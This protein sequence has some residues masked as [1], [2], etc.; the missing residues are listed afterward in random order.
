MTI[1]KDMVAN[2]Q[3]SI[4]NL[5]GEITKGEITTVVIPQDPALE[6][7]IND[8]IREPIITHAVKITR[9][10]DFKRDTNQE[11]T[12]IK[13]GWGKR[14]CVSMHVSTTGSGKSVLQTQSALCFIH[15]VACC[16]LEP[17]RPMKVWVIQSEDD[18]DRVANDRDDVIRHLSAD[19]PQANWYAAAHEVKFLS[20]KGKT[21]ATF[22]KCLNDELDAAAKENDKPDVVI[23]NPMNAFFGGDLK[24][25]VDCSA[26]FKGG[27]LNGDTTD[28]LEAI[29][30]RHKVW[31]WIFSHTNKPPTGDELRQWLKDD[32][33]EYKMSGANEIADAVRSVITFLK[34]PNREGVFCF[35]AGKNGRGLGWKDKDGKPTNRL[36][37]RWAD[38]GHYWQPLPYD[39]WPEAGSEP[40]ATPKPSKMDRNIEAVV[41]ICRAHG[42]PFTSKNQ[43]IKAIEDKGLATTRT[44][45]KWIEI[46]KDEGKI[47]TH[48]S[49]GQKLYIGIPE[50]F[51][52]DEEDEVYWQR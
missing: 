10:S 30:D 2:W 21:G 7:F 40:A 46:A 17:T 29:I 19:Y 28:G 48:Q 1:T 47:C 23:I 14:G 32:Y 15:G 36:Y 8:A 37:F 49:D 52:S 44:A 12:L 16:G 43:L 50:Q 3:S 13:G 11:N 25:G 38:D 31:C 5:T 4:G 22:L 39:E 27:K 51:E 45:E 6:K 35:I 9:L 41:E 24:R 26:F 42:C 18:D 34:V 33:P 20:F